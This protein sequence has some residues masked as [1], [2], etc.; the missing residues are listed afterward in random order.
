MNP[1]LSLQMAHKIG[2]LPSVGVVG[3]WTHLQ[4][5]KPDQMADPRV[6]PKT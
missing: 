5:P 1:E 4:S 6:A 3:V 2:Q